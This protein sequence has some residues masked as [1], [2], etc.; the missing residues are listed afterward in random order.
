LLRTAQG[1]QNARA[2]ESAWLVLQPY[3]SEI[4]ASNSQRTQLAQLRT[5]FGTARSKAAL[6]DPRLRPA[7][8]VNLGALDRP[9]VPPETP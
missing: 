2:V 3:G 9:A 7:G 6:G 5:D 1:T 8:G 4:S